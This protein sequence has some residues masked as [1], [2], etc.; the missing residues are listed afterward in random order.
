MSCRTGVRWLYRLES[1]HSWKSGHPVPEDLVFLDRKG[2]V[3]L[4]IEKDGRITV[5]RGYSWNGCSP[6]FC[7]FDLLL[8]TPEGVVHRD[9]GRPKTYYAS[10]VHDALYQFLDT[11][12]PIRRRDADAFFKRLLRESDFGP[13]WLYWLAVRCFG[14]IVRRGTEIKREWQGTSERLEEFGGSEP[15]GHD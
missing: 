4:I 5:T 12:A 1:N 9:T 13:A 7:L 6:K 8:G 2:K 15:G 11:D 3:R 14:W 10:M